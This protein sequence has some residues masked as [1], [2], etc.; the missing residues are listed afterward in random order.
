MPLFGN[1]GSFDPDVE[2]ATNEMRT[3]EDWGLIMDICDKV[4]RT[5]NGPKDCL[6]AIVKR[7]NHKV[8][9]VTMQSLTLLDACVNNCGR[10]FHLEICSRDFVSECRNFIGQK[11]HP[12]VAQKL[13]LLIKRWAEMPEFK[14]EPALNLMPSL[15][16]S[17]KK[18]GHDFSDPDTVPK[19]TPTLI[20][21]PDAV[22]TQQEEDDIAKAIALSLQ[23][24]EKSKTGGSLYPSASTALSSS[25]TLPKSKEYRKVRALYDFEAAEDNE[26]NFK[27]GEIISVQDDTDPNWW[28]GFSHRGEGL[29]PAN[30]VTSNL[31]A[32]PEEMKEK[33]GVQFNE[34][35]DVKVMETLPEEVEVDEAKI[36]QVLALIQ[37]ADPTGETQ[38]DSSELLSLEEQCKI[39]GPLID[40]ELERIDKKHANLVELNMKVMDALQMYHNLM[41][42]NP[43][44]YMSHQPAPQQAPSTYIPSGIPQPPPQQQQQ[45]QQQQQYANQPQYISPGQAPPSIIHAN[46]GPVPQGP[47]P[48]NMMSQQPAPAQSLN[49]NSIVVSAAQQPYNGVTAPAQSSMATYGPTS[50]QFNPQSMNSMSL[51]PMDANYGPP[52]STGGGGMSYQQ[53]PPPQPLL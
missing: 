7:M 9:F 10:P 38:P 30:F 1:S 37:N 40:A 44:F 20:S 14:D 25:N 34:E 5:P 18:E 13:K 27:A 19:K 11:A 48:T 23:E 35:V 24:A 6:R 32:E 4:S 8:P 16:E 31:T 53:V 17:L 50:A 46:N 28:K 15:Y 52:P 41:K 22:Q 26:L 2:K 47:I 36:D 49:G 21:N 39:M 3:T 33:K 12:K 45:Q 43:V 42:E 29:F 51:P